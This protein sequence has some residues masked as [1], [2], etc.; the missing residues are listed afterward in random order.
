[1]K[2]LTMNTVFRHIALA[3]IALLAA[4]NA[5]AGAKVTYV[6]PE[7][8]SDVPFS[9]SDRERVLKDI[10]RHFDKLA[11][12]LPAG[13]QLNVEVTDV[14]LAGQVYPTRFPGQDI[15]IM[16]GGADW[17]R[18]AFRY[19]I[20]Q[21]DQVVKSGDAALSDM[22]YLQMMTRYGGDDALKYEKHMMDQWFKEKIAI[23]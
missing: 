9:T 4:G 6:Q 1:M 8:F 16:N 10:S 21:G 11:A 18:M 12:N 15:R 13:Q 19:T 14:D 2:G 22:S 7:L 20:T 17:P 3:A 5:S 23:R